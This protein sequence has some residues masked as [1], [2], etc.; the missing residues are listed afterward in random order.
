MKPAQKDFDRSIIKHLRQSSP[1]KQKQL[2]Q[3]IQNILSSELTSFQNNHSP[4]HS[5]KQMRVP[6]L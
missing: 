6:K 1:Q 3:R 4:L 5:L 2:R